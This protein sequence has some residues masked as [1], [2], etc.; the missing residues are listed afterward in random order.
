VRISFPEP[1]EILAFLVGI[2]IA[3]AFFRFFVYAL[4]AWAIP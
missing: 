3:I 4:T 1:G 2:P